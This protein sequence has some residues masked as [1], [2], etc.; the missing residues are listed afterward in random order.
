M[1][2]RSQSTCLKCGLTLDEAQALNEAR[3]DELAGH[4]LRE[5]G[6]FTATGDAAELDIPQGV[7]LDS[8]SEK[9]LY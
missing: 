8:R 1:T 6:H 3:R 7:A 5:P 4:G 2:A 9:P